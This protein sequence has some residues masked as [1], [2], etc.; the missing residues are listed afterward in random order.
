MSDGL[1]YDVGA[2]MGED[3]EYYLKRGFS[4]VAVEAVPDYCDAIRARCAAYLEAGKLTVLNLCVAEAAGVAP[5]YVNESSSVWSTANPSWV[6]R[7][8]LYGPQPIREITVQTEPLYEI[9]QKFGV[10]RYCKIDI[11]GNDLIAL[12]SISGLLERPEFVSIESEKLN[13]NA[14]VEEL[15]TFRDLGYKKF[16]VVNQAYVG[17][18]TLPQPSREGAYC[19]HAFEFG[20]S[21]L[22]GDELPGR[23]VDL[24]ECLEIHKQIFRGYFLNGDHG[25]FEDTEQTLPSADWYDTHASRSPL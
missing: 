16:K 11:E 5:F 24:S 25:I 3:T 17:L 19:E 22:F 2:H 13:W 4:V 15:V 14:L 12:K 7:N 9:F 8:N 21:G 10:P 18:Q 20:S 6:E 23:W 1:I